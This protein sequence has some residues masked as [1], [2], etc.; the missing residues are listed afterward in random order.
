M[1]SHV[2]STLLQIISHSVSFQTFPTST[3]FRSFQYTTTLRCNI[4]RG[5]FSPLYVL[6]VFLLSYGNAGKHP[7]VA[8]VK[9]AH[10]QDLR[11]MII[12]ARGERNVL[13]D[14]G[15]SEGSSF[16]NYLTNW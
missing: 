13:L 5:R 14:C 12:C 15:S 16:S 11:I 7:P 10:I 6:S 8:A 3:G 1:A 2:Y 4:S 9:D